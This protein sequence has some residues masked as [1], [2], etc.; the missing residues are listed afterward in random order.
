MAER[1]FVN[2]VD[3]QVVTHVDVRA[4]S[5]AGRHPMSWKLTDSPDPI[6]ASAMPC[7]HI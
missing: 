2:S 6:D 1:E 3:R 7:D 4:A 5:I